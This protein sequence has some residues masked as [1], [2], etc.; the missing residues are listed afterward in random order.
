MSTNLRKDDFVDHAAVSNQKT[1]ASESALNVK[2][3]TKAFRVL[4]AFRDGGPFLGLADLVEVTGMDKSTVQ[5][6]TYT[7][8]QMGYL[9]QDPSTRRYALGRRV[10]DLS[11]GFLNSHTLTARAAPVL[12]DIRQ[13]IQER[14]DLSIPD[15]TS[16]LYVIRM[17]AK[18]EHYSTAL[19]GRRVPVFCT[20]GGRAM[21]ARMPEQD[22]L[23]LVARSNRQ[24]YTPMTITDVDAVMA[25][26]EKARRQG[27]AIQ[28]GEWRL[29]EMVAGAAVTDKE[30]E[31]IAAVHVAV[32]TSSWSLDEMKSR[33]VP[34]LVNAAAAISGM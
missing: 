12:V 13:A 4:E 20:S 16:L 2:S 17:Q 32:S 3:V 29:G 25:E 19:V 26:V 5:R 10:L 24:Q 23:N 33:I 11:Y 14:I 15:D 21:L 34:L 8:K 18:R 31:P 1:A 9:E 30:G 22:A 6:F 27:Y 7:L 28:T